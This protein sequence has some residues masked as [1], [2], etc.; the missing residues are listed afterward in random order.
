MSPEEEEI[1]RVKDATDTL[2]EFFDTVQI[3][4]TRHDHD[5]HDG[6]GNTIHIAYGTGNWFA[7]MGQVQDFIVRKQALT[8]ELGKR[9]L[10]DQ[11]QEI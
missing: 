1:Q 10:P 2:G 3:F 8:E 5:E 11:D 6:E 4:V 7:R 9:D